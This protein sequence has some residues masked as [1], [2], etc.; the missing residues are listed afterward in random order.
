MR[1]ALVSHLT[2]L[3]S[4]G[5]VVPNLAMQAHEEAIERV[6][7]QALA[8][9]GVSAAELDAV[10]VTLGPGLSLCLR[11]RRWLG[12]P[13]AY[14]FMHLHRRSAWPRPGSYRVTTGCH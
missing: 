12:D 5:G 2:A 9:A 8:R 4:E 6:V 13:H 10:A 14:H 3:I 11:V 7:E 1:A